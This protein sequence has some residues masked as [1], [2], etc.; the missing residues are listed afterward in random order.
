MNQD[1]TGMI[2]KNVKDGE[3]VTAPNGDKEVITKGNG[4]IAGNVV[5]LEE[6]DYDSF[7]KA[8]EES[9]V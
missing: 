3:T 8:L 1:Y 4:A 7:V 9:G 2:I 6:S 5:Y